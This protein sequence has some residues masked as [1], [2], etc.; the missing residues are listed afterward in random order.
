MSQVLDIFETPHDSPP[1]WV[2]MLTAYL[3]ESG[4]ETR[5]LM[6]LAGFLGNS[7][8]WGACA[9]NWKTALGNRKNLHMKDLHWSK[10]ERIRRLLCALGPIP[11]EAGLRAV[12]TTAAMSD[13]DDLTAG[14]E[15]DQL[16]KSYMIALM[17]MIHVI[18]ENI[19]PD[20]TFKL[21]LEANDRYAMNVQSLF[22]ATKKLQTSD[23]RSKLIS[24]EFVDKGVTSLTEPADFL[25]YA[26]I[27]RYRNPGSVKDELC[28]PILENTQPC[29]GRQHQL[30][31]ELLRDLVNNTRSK[32]PHL[33]R[34]Q[35]NAV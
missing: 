4:H 31:P 5:N 34:K 14:T 10:P 9:E 25:A 2:F 22:N 26:L 28:A 23:G 20:E 3:D 17:G 6:V 11:H 35:N 1:K 18:A 33:T 19:P 29:F 8:Q 16:Y 32:F 12:F 27:Q 21:V 15:L 30:Q 24:I 13:Y 7:S